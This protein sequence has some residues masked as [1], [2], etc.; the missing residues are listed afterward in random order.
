[1]DT[2]PDI[3]LPHLF[4][5][6]VSVFSHPT[7]D[8]VGIIVGAFDISAVLIYT[9]LNLISDVQDRGVSLLPKKQISHQNYPNPFNPKTIINYELPITNYVDIS[10]YNLLGQ[11]VATLV[12]ERQQAGFHQVEWDASRFSSGVYYYRLEV[13]QFQEVKKMILLR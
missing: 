9:N 5:Y 4:G 2:I 8:Y 6:D 3:M 1:M 10:I 11:K 12:N 13:G 7:E